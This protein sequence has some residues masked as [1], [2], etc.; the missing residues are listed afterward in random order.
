MKLKTKTICDKTNPIIYVSVG[1]EAG[2]LNSHR[3]EAS[4]ERTFKSAWG[5][6]LAE[7]NDD[8]GDAFIL[9]IDTAS[10]EVSLVAAT[11]NATLP[12]RLYLWLF[13]C[14]YGHWFVE[15]S[16]QRKALLKQDKLIAVDFP[17]KLGK[18]VQIV[19]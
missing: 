2:E 7:A 15:C 13:P 8:D 14:G 12:S 18:D 17:K 16:T 1:Y 11:E 19:R 10:N 5:N 3:Y 9:K 4:S 6:V